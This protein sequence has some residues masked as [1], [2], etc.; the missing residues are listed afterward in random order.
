MSSHTQVEKV[1]SQVFLWDDDH[2]TGDFNDV[3]VKTPFAT[4]G[5]LF[6]A[7]TKF[8]PDTPA[9]ALCTKFI[10]TLSGYV[11]DVMNDSTANNE[12]N[13]QLKIKPRVLISVLNSF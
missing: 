1:L 8:Y 13:F 10:L 11:V 5:E 12:L 3:E 4:V 9:S 7:F 6:R 2:F